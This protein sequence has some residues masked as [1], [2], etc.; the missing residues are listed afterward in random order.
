MSTTGAEGRVLI[1][2]L[3]QQLSRAHAQAYRSLMLEA[4]EQAAD[5]FTSTPEERAAEPLS[6][7]E[8]RI[9]APDGLTRCWGAFAGEPVGDLV[10]TVAVEF[11][12]KPKT[13]H[14]AL[15]IGMYVRPHVRGAG[16]GVQLLQAA[17]AGARER[18]GIEMLRLTVT[19]GNAS[20]IH[21]YRA[22]GFVP[23]GVEPLAIRTPGGY[24]GKVHMALRLQPP[25]RPPSPPPE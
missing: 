3:V 22:A 10:G 2:P 14:A 9:A 25:S 4:Y 5:A 18:P 17:I 13:R 23:W 20:A 21:L 11:T 24:K 7:W 15:V 8:D 12:R 19:E 6:F 1:E 16:I